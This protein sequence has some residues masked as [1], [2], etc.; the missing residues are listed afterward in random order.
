LRDQ[1]NPTRDADLP[2]HSIRVIDAA[3]LFAGPLIGSLLG[4]YGADVIKIEHP[5]GDALRLFGWKKKDVSLWW[6]VVSRNKRS[7][8]LNLSH[9]R[10]RDL[11]RELLATADVFI[12]NFRP[13]TL[14]RWGLD[15]LEVLRDNPRLVVIRTTG[16]GQTGPYAGRAGFGT[17]AE[18]MSGFAHINGWPDGPP[19]LPP[20]ALADSVAALTGAFAAMLAL[21]WRD[22]P[23]G[24]GQ[25]VDLS[26]YEPMFWV[27]GPQA[28]AYQQLGLVQDRTGNAAPFTAP[29]NVYRSKDGHWLALSAAVQ[30][31]AER[32]MAIVGREELT[33]E[34]WFADNT[35]RLAHAEELDTIIGSWIA[36]RT[37]AE[38]LDAFADNDAAIAPVMSIA[39]IVHDPQYLARETITEVE[40]PVLGPLQMQNVIPRL[41]ETPGRVRTPG[42]ELGEHNREVLVGELGL[43][44][45]TLA[46]LSQLGVI[47]STEGP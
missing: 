18:A 35:G 8:T 10:G 6:A 21:W 22:Q 17:L 20:L 40:H 33:H 11:M 37:A 3:T 19:T 7:V 14:E 24:K 36:E 43:D 1:P 38:V 13:G 5:K 41:T 46:E 30:P 25:V 29:R 47:A 26:I 44:D 42:P 23:G 45:K 4:D 31:I 28:L 2:L 32:V 27:L 16:F 39:E 15:P 9:P 12:E 34:P